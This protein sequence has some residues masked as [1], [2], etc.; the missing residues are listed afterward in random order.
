LL[1]IW[2][3]IRNTLSPGRRNPPGYKH[4]ADQ[5]DAMPTDAPT[6]PPDASSWSTH[7]LTSERDA[8][9]D[10]ITAD[11]Q[12]EIRRIAVALVEDEGSVAPSS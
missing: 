6:R 4:E 9:L 5:G 3:R 10:T 7:D 11:K 2:T 12:V 1:A 8:D